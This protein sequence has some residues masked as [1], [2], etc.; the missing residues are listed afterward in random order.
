MLKEYVER[1]NL[2]I[3]TTVTGRI[4]SGIPIQGI[5]SSDDARRIAERSLK[6]NMIFDYTPTQPPGWDINLKFE[7]VDDMSRNESGR[8][9]KATYWMTA[10]GRQIEIGDMANDHIINTIA[11][12]QR[13]MEYLDRVEYDIQSINKA[14][15]DCRKTIRL[16]VE[17]LAY[18]DENDIYI[19]NS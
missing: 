8:I 9:K 16:F 19:E 12:M 18:R 17:E 5:T 1:Q 11:Y 15:K 13:R 3:R 10:D 2:N 4:P 7:G 6:H 14:I